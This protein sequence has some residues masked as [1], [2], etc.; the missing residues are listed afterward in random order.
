MV[1]SETVTKISIDSLD[2]S[3]ELLTSVDA[4]D[5]PFLSCYLDLEAG[6]ESCQKF[7]VSEA[8]F[9]RAGLS[10]LQR[11]D[12]DEAFEQ[13]DETIASVCKD[14][15]CGMAI[16]TRSI[17]GGRFVRVIPSMLPFRNQLTFY[18]VPDVRPLLG[19]RD[20]YGEYFMLW[21]ASDGIELFRVEG[22]RAQ[23]LAWVAEKSVAW[24]APE[25]QNSL[26]RNRMVRDRRHMDG[27]ARQT[28][29]RAM[30]ST[31]RLKLVLAGDNNRLQRLSHWLPRH[32]S[33]AV[34]QM[35]TVSPFL[36]RTK[37][38]RQIIDH[39]AAGCRAAVD[40]FTKSCL[41]VPSIRR[42][43]V[44]GPSSTFSAIDSQVLDTLLV[45]STSAPALVD[46]NHPVTL[47]GLGAD[48]G[49][50]SAATQTHYWDPGIE[51]SRL[52]CQQGIRTLVSNAREL[53]RQ[54]G[55]GGLLRDSA[56]VTVMSQPKHPTT[57]ELVA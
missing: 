43:C 1:C 24:H 53:F 10:E 19:L 4:A 6:V 33:A 9:I 2:K 25:R 50:F 29:T 16:F 52:A 31:G 42:R 57:T 12:F 51:L 56:D 15:I 22:G 55:V 48:T 27:F 20:A 34:S 26:S 30:K 37:A 23:T 45:A 47:D 46:T 41:Q 8:E 32:L 18:R 21:A 54:G 3:I 35:V 17:M 7:L 14:E 11:L 38:L 28:I 40:A 13:L 44:T 39:T 49:H 36:A 5:A